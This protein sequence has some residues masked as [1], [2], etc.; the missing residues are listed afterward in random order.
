MDLVVCAGF[1][2][3]CATENMVSVWVKLLAAYAFSVCGDVW[4]R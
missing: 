2:E 4:E 3:F 1:I